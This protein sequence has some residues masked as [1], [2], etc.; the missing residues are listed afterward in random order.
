MSTVGDDGSTKTFEVEA[1]N[2]K[3]YFRRPRAAS[4]ECFLGLDLNFH[5]PGT[6]SYISVPADPTPVEIKSN[7]LITLN[8]EDLVTL[9]DPSSPTLA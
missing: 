9:N 8:L 7:G 1:M 6:W 2:D 5:M 3:F 4:N